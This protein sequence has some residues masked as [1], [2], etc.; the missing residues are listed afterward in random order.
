MVY[1]NDSWPSADS[2]M[3]RRIRRF[4]WATTPLGPIAGWSQSLKTIVDLMLRSPSMMSLVW[5]VEAIHL[6]NDSF[7]ELL[8]EQGQ[9]SLGRPAYEIFARS[10]DVFAKE[11]VA[12]MA[13]SSARLTGQ[14]YPVLRNGRFADAWFD[15]EYAP[16]HDDAG[17]I[18]GVLWTFKETTVQHLAERDIRTSE[19]RHRLLIE[20]W[21]QAVWE[22]D[23]AGV[24]AAD[25]PSW[26]AYTGQT[27]EEW[28]GYGWLNAIHPDDCAYAKQQWQEAVA[29]RGLVNA[30][31][32]LRTPDAG[33]RW[34]NVRA[35]PVLS[36]EG[37]IEK[38]VG[39][40][41]DIDAHKQAEEALRESEE[42]YRSLFD[43]SARA[44]ASSR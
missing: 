7:A 32:R 24:V 35:A 41:I 23:S 40:N 33:W 27:L 4:A 5:G 29:A 2:E 37:G 10:R 15:V 18:A 9:L 43:R 6:Y 8:R 3:A 26:R 11:L 28:L 25:S 44:S 17:G 39:M 22:T 1:S 34:T 38:W 20:S 36:A 19:T 31:F 16:V 13:G 21:A 12:G 42:R 14:R 30:E